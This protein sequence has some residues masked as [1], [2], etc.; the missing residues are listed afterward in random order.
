MT[1]QAA[2]RPTLTIGRDARDERFLVCP[3]CH[4]ELAARERGRTC[5]QCDRFYPEVAGLLDLRLQSDRYLD[6]ESER[7]VAEELAAFEPTTDAI[8]L[9]DRYFASRPEVKGRGAMFLAQ[10]ESAIDRGEALADLLPKAGRVLEVG[11]GTGGLLV[12][13][14]RRGIA[15][16]GIDVAARRLVIARRRLKDHHVHVPLIIAQAERSPYRAGS[17]DAIVLDS[18]LEHLPDPF[19]A[20]RECARTL[21]PGGRLIVWSPNRYSPLMDPHVG[22][23]GVGFLPRRLLRPY[24]RLR[25]GAIEPIACL[26]P[27]E[28]RKLADQAGFRSI[29]IEPPRIDA[30]WSKNRSLL[31]SAL[32]R[33]YRSTR[34]AE[35]ARS[36]AL[37]FGPLWSLTAVR[38]E[39]TCS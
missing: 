30:D 24:V 33:I 14:R 20:M 17:F 31:R 35:P 27:R 25:R 34:V 32:M 21:K 37:A 18:V 23:W 16:E 15:I 2:R 8:G 29:A 1:I 9:A 12:A 3:A 5:A 26:S 10:V 39:N 38:G 7:A 22:L 36:L 28:A 11:C 4:G 19:A 13:A 6:L